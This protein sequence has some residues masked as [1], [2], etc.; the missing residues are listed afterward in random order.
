MLTGCKDFWDKTADLFRI[1]GGGGGGDAAAQEP[2]EVTEVR[3]KTYTINPE[4]FE[5]V[6]D[7]DTDPTPTHQVYDGA[8]ELI[9]QSAGTLVRG[10]GGAANVALETGDVLILRLDGTNGTVTLIRKD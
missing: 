2:T 6:L 9:M 3:V 1:N 7:N 4:E 10:T 8:T 5:V